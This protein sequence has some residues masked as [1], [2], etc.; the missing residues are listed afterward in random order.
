VSLASWS[1]FLDRLEAEVAAIEG[2][3]EAHV[4]T[5]AGEH[6]FRAPRPQGPLPFAERDRAQWLLRRMAGAEQKLAD[7]M[8]K[9]R[10]ELTIND[11]LATAKPRRMAHYVDVQF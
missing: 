6:P 8:R 1:S 4:A 5:V 2:A 3:D 7:S 11:R 9:V 10:Q